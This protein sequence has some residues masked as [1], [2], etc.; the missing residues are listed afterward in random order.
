M[1]IFAPTHQDDPE[2]D[3][4]LQALFDGKCEDDQNQAIQLLLYIL[5]SETQRAAS[6]KRGYSAQMAQL[7]V[8]EAEAERILKTLTEQ[9]SQFDKE[10]IKIDAAL[11]YP[12]DF[13]SHCILAAT[14]NA[15][16]TL[17]MAIFTLKMPIFAL[18][19]PFLH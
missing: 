4:N 18:K 3:H 16:L 2:W 11:R 6:M 14:E 17:K 19:M 13:G 5:S 12:R 7:Q 8:K 10:R 15:I 1:T 9:S